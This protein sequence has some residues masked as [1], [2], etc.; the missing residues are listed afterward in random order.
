MSCNTVCCVALRRSRRLLLSTASQERRS[1]MRD[2]IAANDVFRCK[3][4]TEYSRMFT[5]AVFSSYGGNQQFSVL[6]RR[7]QNK[8]Y[9][10][11]RGPQAMEH[12]LESYQR[13]PEQMTWQCTTHVPEHVCYSGDT[14]VAIFFTNYPKHLIIYY[15][16]FQQD[17]AHVVAYGQI[18]W[19]H[20]P[21]WFS[22][23]RSPQS[24]RK[25][26]Y[27]DIEMHFPLS[28]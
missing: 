9:Y 15:S 21:Q 26:Q 6:L 14:S 10:M 25:S 22:S 2:V 8:Q 7:R 3:L 18:P 27:N 20:L 19:R 28:H 5:S 24:S 1:F 12:L 13:P 16:S 4:K 17:S 23:E 11:L